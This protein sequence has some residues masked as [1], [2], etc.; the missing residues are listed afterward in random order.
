[1]LPPPNPARAKHTE[2][3]RAFTD[4]GSS[5]GLRVEARHTISVLGSRIA[6]TVDSSGGDAGGGGDV[7]RPGGA[8]D[9]GRKSML[10]RGL[11]IG[12]S[13]VG[14]VLGRDVGPEAGG[15][16][17]SKRKRRSSGEVAEEEERK[18]RTPPHMVK[19]ICFVGT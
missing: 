5:G 6:P 17:M 15:V 18:E 7:P 14:A 4:G 8:N 12:S 3:K 2:Q 9:V 16:E 1:M 13:S 10:G 11:A 19:K